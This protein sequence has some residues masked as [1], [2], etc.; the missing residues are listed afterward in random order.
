MVRHESR[1]PSTQTWLL[2]DRRLANFSYMHAHTAS[3]FRG[4]TGIGYR[5]RFMVFAKPD[6][7]ARLNSY[8]EG[9][10][11]HLIKRGAMDIEADSV[12]IMRIIAML[13]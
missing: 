8:Q 4:H 3:P 1:H 2:K 7:L 13:A 6:R 10:E 12:E 9:M 5:D 11:A